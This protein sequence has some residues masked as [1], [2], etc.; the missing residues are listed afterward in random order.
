MPAGASSGQ[1][2]GLSF[3]PHFLP[4]FLFEH[5]FLDSYLIHILPVCRFRSGAYRRKWGSAHYRRLRL[6]SRTAHTI[7]LVRLFLLQNSR[8]NFLSL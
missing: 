2:S 4:F 8:A 6:N 5:D 3:T 7:V 1:L